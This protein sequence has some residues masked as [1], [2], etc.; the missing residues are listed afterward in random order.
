MNPNISVSR[1]L[2]FLHTYVSVSDKQGER[3]GSLPAISHLT[4]K[5]L[6]H[7][8][9]RAQEVTEPYFKGEKILIG[10]TMRDLKG[11]IVI[12]QQKI[13]AASLVLMSK[14]AIRIALQKI[15]KNI[16][17]GR[18]IESLQECRKK[19]KESFLQFYLRVLEEK[20]FK[21]HL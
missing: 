16:E 17:E 6:V 15:L 1:R 12:P 21:P 13:I 4:L 14:K 5:P 10:K 20:E 9:L 8:R 7:A 18:L 3:S 19:L 2:H 11:E